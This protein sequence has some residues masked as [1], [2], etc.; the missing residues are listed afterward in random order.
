MTTISDYTTLQSA[1]VEY[2]GRDQDATLVARVPTFIQFFEAKM[3]RD[4]RHRKME[5]R[6]TTTVDTSDTEPEFISLPS[7]FQ[8]MQRIRLSSYTGKPSID[9]RSGT[10]ADDYRFKNANTTG[11]PLFYTVVGDEIELLPTPDQNYTIEMVYRKYIPA[12]ASYSTNW[13]LSLAPD[14]YLYGT[15]LEAEPYLKNDPRIATW[16]LGYKTALDS[17]NEAQ[18]SA[19]FATNPMQMRTSGVTP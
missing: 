4:L 11:R 6:S 10:Q 9:Y 15:L 17:L 16:G 18:I 14:L 7:D 8:S 12:L 5:Q 2:L 3:N 1:A 13:L 19:D